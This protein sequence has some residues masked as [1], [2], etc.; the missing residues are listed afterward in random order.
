MDTRY[1]AFTAITNSDSVNIAGPKPLTDA[2]F[3]GT[4][5]TGGII[6]AIQQDGNTVT[7]NNVIAGTI[8][9]IAVKRVNS[10]TTSASNLIAC[11]QV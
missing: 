4:A 2:I 5:G 10:S 7:L 9:P 3:V 6:V 8:Y 1:N 11:Y